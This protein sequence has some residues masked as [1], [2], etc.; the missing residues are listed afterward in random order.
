MW[1]MS[2]PDSPTQHLFMRVPQTELYHDPLS[3]PCVLEVMPDVSLSFILLDRRDPFETVLPSSASS[4]PRPSPHR[5]TRSDC[6][7]RL[8]P[9]TRG[10]TWTGC[11]KRSRRRGGSTPARRCSTSSRSSMARSSPD[12]RPHRMR[13]LCVRALARGRWA[14]WRT[15][16]CTPSAGRQS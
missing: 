12:N 15:R 7:S 9:S 14:A 3:E 6:G 4:H 8:S 2:A 11:M 1:K 16:T 5:R 10:T 13:S